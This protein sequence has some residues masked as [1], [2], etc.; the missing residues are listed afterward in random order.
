[1]SVRERLARLRR[2]IA[3]R[4]AN[5]DLAEEEYLSSLVEAARRL[6]LYV[7]SA[8][9]ELQRILD[10]LAR[11]RL[12]TP[13]LF[14]SVLDRP[15]DELLPEAVERML[16]EMRERRRAPPGRVVSEATLRNELRRELVRM[17]VAALE[18]L[19]VEYAFAP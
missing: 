12:R 19:L 4:V 2:E 15:L 18:Q 7:P 17:L 1:M 6:E 9:E 16:E 11:R 14:G 5:P 8:T 13:W 3:E 10:D